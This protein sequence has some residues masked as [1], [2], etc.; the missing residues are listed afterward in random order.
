MLESQSEAPASP[1]VFR[2]PL[3]RI[4]RGLRVG[5]TTRRF[6]KRAKGASK[7]ALALAMGYRFLQ[8]VG[9][10]EIKDFA[11]LARKLRTSRAW[12]SMRV[13][14]TFLAPRIQ[15]AILLGTSR[16]PSIQEL[17][18]IARLKDWANQVTRWK[19]A[20]QGS[21]FPAEPRGER[22]PLS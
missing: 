9:G 2:A 22:P 18:G 4:Q 12:V 13:E 5:F 19:G 21:G 1:L 14:L 7:A 6:A 11:A 16:Q 20:N 15:E 8:E 10:G 17:V 3:F